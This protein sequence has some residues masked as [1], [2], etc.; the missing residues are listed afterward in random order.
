MTTSTLTPEIV[1]AEV[2][3]FWNAFTTKSSESLEEFYAHES[4][5]FGSTANRAEPGRLAATRRK[6][7]Y[8]H[9]Q[10]TL[11]SQTG[12]VDVVMLGDQAA[13]A[14]YTFQFHAT[15][16][17]SA[18]LSKPSEEHITNGRATQV[19][20]LDSDGAIRIFHEHFSI[21]FVTG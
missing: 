9:A 19:F 17:A 15:K 5:V 20:G 4:S 6:R 12:F 18:A 13:V 3:R 21:P 7:E 10:S 1:R 16:V 8:F 2:A 11:R 14:C